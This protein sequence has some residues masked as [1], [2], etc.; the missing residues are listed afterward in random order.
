[1]RYIENVI[2]QELM[3]V[4]ADLS[5]SSLRYYWVL[6]LILRKNNTAE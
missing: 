2:N 6:I 3:I 1:M 5:N 4:A